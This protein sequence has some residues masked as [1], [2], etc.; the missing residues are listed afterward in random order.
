M[1][2]LDVFV[3]LEAQGLHRHPPA[4]HHEGVAVLVGGVRRDDEQEAVQLQQLVGFLAAD[5]ALVRRGEVGE[6]Q[7]EDH[8]VEQLSGQGVDGVVQLAEEG[9]HCIPRQLQR[10]LELKVEEVTLVNTLKR[11]NK[12]IRHTMQMICNS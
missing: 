10:L 3:A 6:E 8:D 2:V 11:H 1:G 12:Q 5:P 9:F 4:A 7:G